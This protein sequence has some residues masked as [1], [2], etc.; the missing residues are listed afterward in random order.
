MCSWF[1]VFVGY[2]R[3]LSLWVV[4]VGLC[5]ALLWYVS[6]VVGLCL[7]CLVIVCCCS[8]VLGVVG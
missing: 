5:L 6:V 8:C 7:L 1:R 2:L 3:L 4:R